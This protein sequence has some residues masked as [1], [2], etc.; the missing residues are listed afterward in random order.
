MALCNLRISLVNI[1][2]VVVIVS[3]LNNQNGASA[4]PSP[5]FFDAIA[6]FFKPSRQPSGSS[7]SYGAPK[8]ISYRPVTATIK[9]NYNR[10][11]TGSTKPSY[12]RPNSGF[13][14]VKIP[15][16]GGGGIPGIGGGGIPKLPRFKL[17]KFNFPSFGGKGKRPSG[18]A[19][20]GPPKKPSYGQNGNGSPGRPSRPIGPAQHTSPTRR[21]SYRPQP[22]PS[23]PLPVYRP[24]QRPNTRPTQRPNNR[25]GQGRPVRPGSLPQY[26][27]QQKPGRPSIP[28]PT[29]PA[30][31]PTQP[32]CNACSGPWNTVL[33][34]YNQQTTNSATPTYFPT[35]PSTGQT[36]L[37]PQ[38]GQSVT[39]SNSNIRNKFPKNMGVIDSSSSIDS[40]GSPQAPVIATIS[41]VVE[42]Y[43]NA[44]TS[45]ID[46]YGSPQAPVAGTISATGSYGSPQA[47]VATKKPLDNY[48]S[49][50]S[51]NN[52][53]AEE[54]SDES[55]E[56]DDDDD[57]SDEDEDDK[58]STESDSVSG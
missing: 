21:P 52:S 8:P 29:Q 14:G 35:F 53:D 23:G 15:G 34:G 13:G 30:P 31:R 10:P 1:L 45:S 27:G 57:D 41:P 5:L 51:H 50:N 47:P 16:I 39:S 6:N 22:G 48:G 37:Q 38:Y 43:N 25:P 7:S 33:P 11:V 36:S 2:L 3:N 17:P 24:A 32:H 28:R 55:E 20:Y 26:G 46:S 42:T 12:N 49:S 18:A 44:Q 9:P 56:D 40:Y 58:D 54:N 4:S 19:S